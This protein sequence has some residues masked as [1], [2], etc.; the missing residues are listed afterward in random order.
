MYTIPPPFD[1]NST[2]LAYAP[3]SHPEFAAADEIILTYITNTIRPN[4]LHTHMET[5]VPRW[6]RVVVTPK[7]EGE[8]DGGGRREE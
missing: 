5:Y 7:G 8:D 3:N 4:D 1:D 6:V 2:Y